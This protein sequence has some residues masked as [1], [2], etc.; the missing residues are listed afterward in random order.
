VPRDP[1]SP[2]RSIFPPPA[3][4]PRGCRSTRPGGGAWPHRS[5]DVTA[6]R[7]PVGCFSSPLL[8]PGP[9]PGRTWPVGCFSSP[10]LCPGPRPGRTWPAGCL[11]SLPL[12]PGPRP[13]R[14]RPRRLPHLAS[15]V[16]VVAVTPAVRRPQ[17][18]RCGVL[19]RIPVGAAAVAGPGR[20]H[21]PAELAGPDPTTRHGDEAAAS[22]SCRFPVPFGVS[23]ALTVTSCNVLRCCTH[24]EGQLSM[25]QLSI[26]ALPSPS[27]FQLELAHFSRWKRCARI[28]RL[29][30][31]KVFGFRLRSIPQ[32]GLGSFHLWIRVSS[33]CLEPHIPTVY[34]SSLP[35]SIFSAATVA[36][37]S[38]NSTL[39][40]ADILAAES[41]Y[42][43]P[44]TDV[45]IPVSAFGTAYSGGLLANIHRRA[46]VPRFSVSEHSSGRAHQFLLAVSCL[47]SA[48][49][50]RIFRSFTTRHCQRHTFG[51]HSRYLGRQTCSPVRRYSCRRLNRNTICW[52]PTMKSKQRLPP[53]AQFSS[54]SVQ[55]PRRGSCAPPRPRRTCWRKTPPRGR[56]APALSR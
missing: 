40:F 17:T 55:G 13:G 50:D 3:S 27:L 8:C 30:E 1:C 32:A 35:A 19:T 42:G 56:R 22:C 29:F 45:E 10:L 44:S 48:C 5:V 34:L 41:V 7:W 9:R 46:P 33:L 49:W 14:T 52:P 21:S 20:S 43:I 24:L 38:A 2:G 16:P 25:P 23:R 51:H 4:R 12:C 31:P 28:P 11:F 6:A 15:T 53:L 47:V 36:F 37:M 54:N 18:G 26:V 39:S